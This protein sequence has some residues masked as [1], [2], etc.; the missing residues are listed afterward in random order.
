MEPGRWRFGISLETGDLEPGDIPIELAIQVLDP[1]EAP[2]QAREPGA[3]GQAATPAAP[4]PSATPK[5]TPEADDDGG[6]SSVSVVAGGAV[7][8]LLGLIGGFVGIAEAAHMT[9]ALVLAVALAL[10]APS[11]ALAQTSAPVV[12]GGSFVTAPLI[13]PGKYRD[14]LLPAERLFYGI[15]L[16]AG[17]RLRVA[18]QLDVEE[19]L[20][21]DIASAFS[22]GIETPLREVEVL[23]LVD[24][25]IAG[26]DSLD[27]RREPGP[28]GVRVHAGARRLRR[29]RGLGQLPRSGHLV[30]VAVPADEQGEAGA[31]RGPGRLRARGDRRAA[32]RR[33]PRADA[34]G[35]H[36]RSLPGEGRLRRRAR[37]RPP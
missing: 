9:R 31:R 8:L 25:D 14:T 15:K 32:A 6:G 21:S 5:A 19:E 22:V 18:A 17:Q 1:N 16:E 13:E 33:Q 12:G 27:R 28:R 35:G 7:G 4:E 29:A 3:P 36:A 23:D 26:N 37:R 11:A 2:G 34:R 10:A 30:R 24:E 20:G